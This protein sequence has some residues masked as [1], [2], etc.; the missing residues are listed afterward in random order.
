MS[1]YKHFKNNELIL[2]IE[3]AVIVIILLTWLVFEDQPEQ[4]QQLLIDIT[5]PV[6]AS[7]FNP[8]LFC[9]KA[10]L[11]FFF[12]S[13]GEELHKVSILNCK[14]LRGGDSFIAL[15]D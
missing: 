7:H 15:H 13:R 12:V 4:T 14:L 2:I 8:G 6:N 11:F 1:L 5:E 10:F 3:H 9:D